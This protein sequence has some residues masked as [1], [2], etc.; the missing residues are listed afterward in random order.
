METTGCGA[1]FSSVTDGIAIRIHR[2]LPYLTGDPH[3][4]LIRN[5]LAPLPKDQQRQRCF[6]AE[7]L[8]LSQCIHGVGCLETDAA[9]P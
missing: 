7:Y 1:L 2:H 4:V 3:L 8:P 9:G 5:M 6:A